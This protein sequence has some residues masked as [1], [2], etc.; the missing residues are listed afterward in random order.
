MWHWH[1]F[2]AGIFGL[3]GDSYAMCLWGMLSFRVMVNGCHANVWHFMD[4]MPSIGVCHVGK[5]MFLN[6]M[7][8]FVY[9]LPYLVDGNLFPCLWCGIIDS[10]AGGMAL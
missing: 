1:Y 3:A 9:R 5:G 8:C 4:S 6:D 7:P 10:H 2:H